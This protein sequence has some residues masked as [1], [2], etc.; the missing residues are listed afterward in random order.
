M[1]TRLVNLQLVLNELGVDP[2]IETLDKRVTF[3]KAIYLAQAAGIP[4][5]YRYSWYRMGPYSRDLT[6]DYY[7]LY[8]YSSQSAARATKLEIR[9]PFASVLRKLRVEMA[10]PCHSSLEQ[11]EWLEL[12][13]SVHYL[14]KNVQLDANDTQRRLNIEKPSLS[15]HTTRA[16]QSLIALGLIQE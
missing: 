11:R 12:L 10:A 2:S 6:R 16:T 4:L 14:R 9:E 7:A 1:D 15:G 8:E 3:Q 13:S 5:H